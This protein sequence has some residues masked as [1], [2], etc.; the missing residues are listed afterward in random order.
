MAF[1][2]TASWHRAETWCDLSFSPAGVAAIG[3]HNRARDQGRR[4]T[5]E[6]M[7]SGSH[8]IH[9]PHAPH[10]GHVQPDLVHLLVL[11]SEGRE[12]GVYVGRRD[13]VDAHTP[14]GP[15]GSQ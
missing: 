14:R 9:F 12:R 5:G 15:F 6:E 4:V 7:D 11:L 2:S 1:G 10:R 3:E 8:F 13:R